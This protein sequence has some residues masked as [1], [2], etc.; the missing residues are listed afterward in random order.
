M[1]EGVGFEAFAFLALGPV[2]EEP[3]RGMSGEDGDNHHRSDA[4]RGHPAEQPE[5]SGELGGN[6]QERKQRGDVH[7]AGEE[8][9]RA[10]KAVAPEPAARRAG[11]NWSRF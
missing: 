4:E 2:H 3:V 5:R 7:G 10:R 8:L 1:A 6:R 11:R 9:H